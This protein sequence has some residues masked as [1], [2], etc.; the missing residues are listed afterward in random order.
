MEPT[1]SGDD[2]TWKVCLWLRGQLQKGPTDS[3]DIRAAAKEQ[4]FTRSEIKTAKRVLGVETSHTTRTIWTW[5]LPTERWWG[6]NGK[7]S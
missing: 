3:R 7:N 1:H 5:K 6:T 2:H 4:G